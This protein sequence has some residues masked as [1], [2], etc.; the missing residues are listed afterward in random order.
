[1]CRSDTDFSSTHVVTFK[2]FNL[3]PYKVSSLRVFYIMHVGQPK[4]HLLTTGWSLFV[5]SKRLR[6][7]DSVLFIRYVLLASFLSSRYN[8]I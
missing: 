1:M 6:A 4:R 7:G 3:E 8:M 2:A 5:G